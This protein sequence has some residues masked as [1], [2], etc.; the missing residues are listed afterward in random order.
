[1]LVLKQHRKGLLYMSVS[2]VYGC[3]L[4]YTFVLC[5][6][7]MRECV[8]SVVHRNVSKR[9]SNIKTVA[10]HSSEK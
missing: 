1:M 2:Y 5:M 3:V 9:A 7:S 10:Q 6:Y 4:M 8:L